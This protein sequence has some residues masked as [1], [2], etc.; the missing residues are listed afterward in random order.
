MHKMEWNRI[1]MMEKETHARLLDVSREAKAEQ[2]YKKW[3]RYVTLLRYDYLNKC[4]ACF[5]FLLS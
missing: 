3:W 4:I 2:A 5:S 1:F